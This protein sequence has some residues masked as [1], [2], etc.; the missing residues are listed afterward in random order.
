MKLMCFISTD[1]ADFSLL[2]I[3]LFIHLYIL[4]LWVSLTVWG[5]CSPNAYIQ[6]RVSETSVSVS[7]EIF[8]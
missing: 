4:V 2:Y 7:Y 3:Y 6:K 1:H 8:F 5:S